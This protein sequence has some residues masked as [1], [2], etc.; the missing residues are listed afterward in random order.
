MALREGAAK[1]L[2]G[3]GKDTKACVGFMPRAVCE[4]GLTAMVSDQC[5]PATRC[6]AEGTAKPNLCGDDSSGEGPVFGEL[7][8]FYFSD[9]CADQDDPAAL[10]QALARLS[11]VDVVGLTNAQVVF[12]NQ[13][14][15][16]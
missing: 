13:P 16:I 5:R 8:K 10:S 1:H 12:R 4:K 2:K 11:T 15:V 9:A 14:P 7:L 6:W 3:A